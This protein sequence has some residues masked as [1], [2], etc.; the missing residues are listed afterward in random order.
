[1]APL[2]TARRIVISVILA[3]CFVGLGYGLSLSRGTSKPIIYTDPAVKSLTP[4]PGDLA[5]RQA[6]IG[7]TLAPEFTLA[8]A[9]APG[10][11]I[12]GTGIPQDQ[13]DIISGLN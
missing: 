1:M 13:L 3:A 7:V 8:Q 6:T 9:N 5:L 12:N 10:F 11:S 4:Q 2:I